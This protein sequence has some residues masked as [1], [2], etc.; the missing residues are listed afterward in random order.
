MN[1]NKTA[2][3]APETGSMQTPINKVNFLHVPIR[4]RGKEVT[5]NVG[6]REGVMRIGIAIGLPILM[7]VIDARLMVY[8]TPV[9]IYLFITGID[10]FCIFKYWWYR[11]VKHQPTPDLP[12]YGQDPNYPEESL[13]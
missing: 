1:N 9:L 11:Y 8:T 6:V 2:V 10:H 5:L 7:L 4:L 12:P 3:P 13:P